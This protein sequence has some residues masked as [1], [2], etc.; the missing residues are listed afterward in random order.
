MLTI[1]VDGATGGSYHSSGHQGGYSGIAAVARTVE[2]YFLGWFSQRLG[3]LTNN[4]AEYRAALLGLHLAKT[5]RARQV[6]IV[7]DSEVMVRQMTGY[8]RVNSQRL[9]L[10][11]QQVCRRAAEFETV[12]FHHVPREENALADALA[13]EALNGRLVTMPAQ[14]ASSSSWWQQLASK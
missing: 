4:E 6:K 7:S 9:K 8:S 10:L 2:G 3:Q 5:L 12:H 13:A 11:H 14:S 1:Y